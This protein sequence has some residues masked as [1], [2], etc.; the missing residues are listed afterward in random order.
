ME[1]SAVD[2]TGYRNPYSLLKSC[3]G[4]GLDSLAQDQ[5][6]CNMYVVGRRKEKDS[7]GTILSQFATVL[8]SEYGK[9]VYLYLQLIVMNNL[10]VYYVHDPFV[11]RLCHHDVHIYRETIAHVIFSS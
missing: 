1:V 3:F 6:P 8:A 10:P 9:M 2:K 7:G 4:S 11:H 5:E